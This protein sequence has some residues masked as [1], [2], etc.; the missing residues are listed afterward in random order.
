MKYLP[1]IITIGRLVGVVVATYLLFRSDY[2]AAYL[3]FFIFYAIGFLDCIDG[4]VARKFDAVTAFGKIMDPIVDKILIIT[5]YLSFAFLQHISHL[6]VWPIIIREVLVTLTR[7]ILLKRGIIIAAERSGKIK[8]FLQYI[9]LNFLFL[10]YLNTHYWKAGIKGFHVIL[11]VS[12]YSFLVLALYFTISSGTDFF[13]K[14]WHNI[15][16]KK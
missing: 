14:N 11:M 3:S 6:W 5:L 13:K 1:N 16:P 7:M 4:Y 8:A 12:S 9:S 15:F 2:N 10:L